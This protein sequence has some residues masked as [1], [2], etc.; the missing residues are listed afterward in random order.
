[1][2]ENSFFFML[3]F[4]G[5]LVLAPMNPDRWRQ[6]DE[7]FDAALDIPESEREAFLSARCDGDEKLRSKILSLLK[8]REQIDGFMESPAMEVAGQTYQTEILSSGLLN[9]RIG[10]YK[11]IE[12]IGA[13][14][15]GE[16]Y[17]ASDEKLKRNVALKILPAEYTSEPERLKRFELEARAISCLNH[18]NIV[19][20]YDVGSVGGINFI[21]TELVEGKSLRQFINEGAKVPEVLNFIIQVCDALSEAHRAGIIHRDI[22]PENIMVRP[23]G[24]IKVLDFGLAKLSA[25][26]P[27]SMTDLANTEHGRIIGTPGYMSPAQINDEG[28]DHRTDLWSTG[29]VLYELLTGK[30]PFKRAKRHDTFEAILS[31]PPPHCSSVNPEIPPLLDRVVEKVLA[32]DPAKG[33]QSAADL[34]IDLRRAKLVVDSSPSWAGHNSGSMPLSDKRYGLGIYAAAAAV[35][36]VF[37]GLAVGLY[38]YYGV[39]EQGSVDWSTA[40]SVPLTDEAGTE[41]FPSISPDGK[42]FIYAAEENGQFDIFSQRVGS[43]T[44]TNLTPDTETDDTQPVY[45]PNGESI[46]FRSERTP[47]GIYVMGLSGDNLKFVS[48]TGYHPSWSPDGSEIVVS[49]FGRDEPTVRASP[50]GGLTKINIVTGAKQ[51]LAKVEASFPAWSPNGHRIAYW[52]YTGTFGRRDIATIPAGGG[53]PVIVAPGFAVSNWNPVWSP[54]GRF[55]YFVSNKLGNM[56]FWRVR[57]DELTGQV[58]SEPETV[59]TPS[60]YSRHPSF[61]S[62]GKRMLYVQTKNQSNIQGIDFDPVAARA[63]SEP[64]WIT[65]GDR[66]ISRAELSTDGKRFAMRL[67]RRTQDDIVTVSRDGKTWRDITN[68]E[69]FD[70]YVRWSPDGKQIA[71]VSDRNEGGQVWVSN[72]DGANPRQITFS[73]DPL[74]S[75]GFPVWSPKGDRL[76]VY[77]DGVTSLLDPSKAETDQTPLRISNGSLRIVVWDWS[78]DGTKL[79]GVIADGNRRHIG[80]YSLET[81]EYKIV[82][83]DSQAA[84]SWLPDSR[85]LMHS[86]GHTIFVTDIETRESKEVLSDPLIDIRSP[87]VS[88]DGKL[89]YYTAGNFES[90]IWMLDLLQEK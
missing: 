62:D 54:D 78:P 51:E 44:R 37:A 46:A 89:L 34:R 47:S 86:D 12:L 45:S 43:K 20:I 39:A 22:K 25:A 35:I 81:N 4:C 77:F 26:S 85:R 24:Y 48:D 2:L 74:N 80:Y 73:K 57:I 88:R 38:M 63:L 69:P 71:F 9:R 21:A 68:D 75:P 60:T 1:M 82:V 55:L 66:Q 41:Y 27:H 58:L 23:D 87:F 19:T 13:G 53:E 61:S 7:L 40:K 16:V 31:S 8:V 84:P 29:V 30:N 32:K 79:A 17:L 15:M 70:R 59:T 18:P 33:Y 67:I 52:F 42:E 14:G 10:T 36:L 64:Y 11:I 3:S 83:E 56:N 49:S 72:A 90:D 65:Q 5:K 76:A 6:I 28:L 50:G